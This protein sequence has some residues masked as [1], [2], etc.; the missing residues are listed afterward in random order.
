M[1]IFSV[2]DELFLVDRRT[3]MTKLTV[4]S[5]NFANAPKSRTSHYKLS[6]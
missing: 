2:G 6:S 4:A 3:V 1:K 5:R